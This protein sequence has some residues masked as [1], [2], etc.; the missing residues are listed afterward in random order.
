MLFHL[1]TS[2]IDQYSFFNV[3]KYLTFRTGLSVITSLV[4]VFIIGA[5]LIKIFSEKMITGPIRQD[6]P[7][8]HIVKKSGTPTMGGVIIIIGI[9]S[10]TL[11]W[12]DLTNFYVWTLIFVSLSLGALGLLDDVLKIKHKNSSGLKSRYKFF[13]QLI[14]SALAL[15]ALIEYSNH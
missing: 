3:F 10:S 12:A 13:G 2:L 14:I 6:G 15:Y 5:P 11:L 1:F 8:D 4:V 7:I 9:I